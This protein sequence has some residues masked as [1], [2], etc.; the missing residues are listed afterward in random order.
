MSDS[1]PFDLSGL[2]ALATAGA[3]G[4]GRAVALGLARAGADVAVAD[5]NPADEQAA[6]D[7]RALGQQSL[8]LQA[9]LTRRAEAERVVAATVERFGRLDVLYNGVGGMRRAEDLAYYEVASLDLTEDD[10]DRAFALTLKSAL[11][12]SIAAARRMVQQGGGCIVNTTSGYARDPGPDRL[13]YSVAKAGVSAMTR[14][15]A[16]EWGRHG[17][18]VNEISPY[19]RTATTA[20]RMDDPVAG[21]RMRSRVALG[22]FAE[23]AEMAGTVV[24]L[25]SRAASYVSGQSI[26][27]NGGR[28]RG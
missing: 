11:F 27:V 8:A 22:R 1:Q 28:T 16:A 4:I 18:R 19:A 3:Q 14:T 15:L 5:I 10:V 13:P 24:Y 12:C 2:V 25:A 7:I 23:P 17:I 21:A 26:E 20:E 6:A 9:D